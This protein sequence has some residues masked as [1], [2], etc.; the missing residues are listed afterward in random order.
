MPPSSPAA[1]TAGDTEEKEEEDSRRR[2]AV[3]LF[4]VLF[5]L[6]AG[7]AYWSH[8]A[9][10][11]P[12]FGDRDEGAGDLT[13]TVESQ[14][15]EAVAGKEV[16]LVHPE[17]GKVVASGT[18]DEDGEVTFR[19]VEQSRYTVRVDDKTHEVTLNSPE[20]SLTLGVTV[21]PPKSSRPLRYFSCSPNVSLS[22]SCQSASATACSVVSPSA[23]V[24]SVSRVSFA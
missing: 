2:K 4:L 1:E 21:T 22:V 13:V 9:P 6:V 15:D 11:A 20:E 3:L 18:T 23:S 24:V 8:S 12:L 5:L 16:S 7:G 10:P 14:R 17:T 19:N